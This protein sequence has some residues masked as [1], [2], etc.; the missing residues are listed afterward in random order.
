MCLSDLIYVHSER[1]SWV[2]QIYFRLQSRLQDIK[3]K[4]NRKIELFLFGDAIQQR[5]N[6]H[7]H[8]RSKFEKRKNAQLSI[9]V[10]ME[11]TKA[12]WHHATAE[13]A[14]VAVAA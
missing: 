3:L 4:N 10:L 7:V 9:V 8:V 11:I 5:M 14:V 12:L 6:A 2:A 13:I 1:I